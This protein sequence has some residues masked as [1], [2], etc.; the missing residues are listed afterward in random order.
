M[1]IKKA[2]SLTT[3]FIGFTAS[4]IAIY[5]FWEQRIPVDIAGDWIMTNTVERSSVPRFRG[6]ELGFRVVLAQDGTKVEGRA[7]KW[8]ENTIALAPSQRTPLTISGVLKGSKVQ[9][10]FIEAGSTRETQSTFNW[11]VESE[12]KLV[13]T[14]RSTAADSEGSSVLSRNR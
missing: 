1:E 4:L 13:G 7:E 5:Q 11:S 6:L 10:T 9:G 8:W 2:A 3:V 12:D 14:F